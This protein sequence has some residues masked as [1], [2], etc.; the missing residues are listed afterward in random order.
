M[1]GSEDRKDLFMTCRENK[2]RQDAVAS[3]KSLLHQSMPG[4]VPDQQNISYS[5]SPAFQQMPVVTT[6]SAD[7]LNSN[8]NAGDVRLV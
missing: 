4:V 5:T 2:D 7:I 8:K 3:R 6:P 1:R